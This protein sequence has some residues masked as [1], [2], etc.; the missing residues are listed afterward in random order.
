[1]RAKEAQAGGVAGLPDRGTRRIGGALTEGEDLPR[2][3]P[4]RVS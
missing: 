2:R 3:G 4:N 1:V